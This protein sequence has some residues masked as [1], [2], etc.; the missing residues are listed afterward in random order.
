[1]FRIKKVGVVGEGKMGSGIFNYLLDYSFGLV[2]VCS[3]EADVDKITR[4]FVRRVKRSFDAG[5]IDQERFDMMMQ[6]AISRNP[7]DLHGCDLVIEAIPEILQLKRNLFMQLDKIV[8]PEAILASN[9]SSINP[10][11]MAPAG[12]RGGKFT[13]LHF[14]YPVALKNIVEITVTAATEEQTLDAVESFLHDI[15]RRFITLAEKNSFMLNKIFLD[16]QNEAF[17]IIQE[18]NCSYLQMDQLVKKNMLPFGVFDFCDSVGLDTM[19]SSI[20]NY[21]RDYPHKSYYSRLI[22]TMSD[23]VSQGKLGMKTHEGFYKYP[24]E[25]TVAAEPLNAAEII[26]HLR[27]TWISSVKRFTAQAHIPIDD[28]NHAVREYFDISKGPFE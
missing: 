20:R 1:M 6:T 16:V 2:W 13:G 11:E 25:E 5:I 26:D 9:S 15:G 22:E 28:A 27:Q 17:L 19:L 8:T 24:M 18:G 7:A 23:L 21:I 14:F 4:Q 3:P 10:S 12:P